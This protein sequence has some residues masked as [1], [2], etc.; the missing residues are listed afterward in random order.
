ML[1]PSDEKGILMLV[2]QNL[3]SQFPVS[4]QKSIVVLLLV[5]VAAWWVL[6]EDSETKIRHAHE[7]LNGLLNKAEGQAASTSIFNARALRELFAETCTVTGNARIFVGIYTP[8]E[9]AA[10]IIQV[11]GLFETID[12]RFGELEVELPA[13]GDA[14]AR[15][16]AVLIARSA[17]QEQVDERRDVTSRMRKT[18]G[19][20]LFTEF[21]L[22]AVPDQP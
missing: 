20:W 2:S 13:A 14:I 19:K 10:T 3:R 7:A 18:G 8:E 9:L 16:S 5:S 21:S 15:F 11:Q 1:E 6:H 12:L 22:T 17:T 4:Y